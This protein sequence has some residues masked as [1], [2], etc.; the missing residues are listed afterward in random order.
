M[1]STESSVELGYVADYWN[2]LLGGSSRKL[3]A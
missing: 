1:S 2:C 3:F